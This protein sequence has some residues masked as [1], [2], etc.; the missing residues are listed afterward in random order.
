M[1]RTNSRPP[2]ESA[3]LPLRSLLVAIDLTAMSDR[4]V[5]R[6]AA[7]RLARDARVTLLHV[8]PTNLA[9]ADQRK[10]E[11]DARKHLATETRQ[12]RRTLP[13]KIAIETIVRHGRPA[14]EIAGRA[15][16]L[17]ADLIVMGRGSGRV[18]PEMFFGTTAARVV[19]QSRLPVLVVRQ[20]PRATYR[21]PGIAIELDEVAL[22]VV[23]VALRVL[24]PPRPNVLAIH[25]FDA[26]YESLVYPSVSHDEST[27]RKQAL[28]TKA[29]FKL[30]KLLADAVAHAKVP[31]EE[32]PSWTTHVRYGSARGVVE[33]VLSKAELDLLV[34]GTRAYTGAAYVFLGSVASDL[35]RA[36]TCDVLVVPP[37]RSTKAR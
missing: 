35:L 9:P 1:K 20:A 32:A 25:A 8:V 6:V 21:Q 2:G 36:A 5:G 12:L 19:R 14:K 10:A 28:Q 29:T 26:P 33:K 30:T 15:K 31:P 23:G 37:L 13:R 11:R 16:A 7:L 22:D 3:P 24:R 34:L 18:L 27:A 4:V 17:K